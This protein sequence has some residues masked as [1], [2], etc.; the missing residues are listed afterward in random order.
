MPNDLIPPPSSSLPETPSR[1]ERPLSVRIGRIVVRIVLLMLIL[2]GAY[3]GYQAYLKHQRAK[4]IAPIRS[5]AL[6]MMVALKNGDYFAAQEH[7]DPS[8][9]PAVS[10]DWIAYFAEHAE[11]NATRTGTWGE[12]NVSREG[13]A[14]VYHLNGKLVYINGHTNPM[15]WT[16]KKMDNQHHVLDLKIGKRSIS[17]TTPSTL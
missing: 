8:M 14:T 17:P 7:L 5:Y 10:I 11:M 13:N 2:W 16:I 12:W 15:K 6:E 4:E 9:Y 1:P 3:V